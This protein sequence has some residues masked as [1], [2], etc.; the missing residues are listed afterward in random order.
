MADISND[1]DTPIYDGGY[2]SRLKSAKRS[3]DTCRLVAKGETDR[4]AIEHF[5][6]LCNGAQPRTTAESELKSVIRQIYRADRTAANSCFDKLAYIFL[7]TEGRAIVNHLGIHHLVYME[8]EQESNKFV[9]TLNDKT[10]NKNKNKY[11]NKKPVRGEPRVYGGYGEQK[12]DYYRPR[13]DPSVNHAQTVVK[14]KDEEKERNHGLEERL[15]AIEETLGKLILT[16]PP[17]PQIIVSPIDSPRE[18]EEI[19]KLFGTPPK[20]DWGALDDQVES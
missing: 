15:S 16:R 9:V 13:A 11:K 17:A 4:D 19:V 14:K 1:I 7:L 8:W 12:S 5:Q 20:E 3:I 6:D 18:A 10:T 2:I